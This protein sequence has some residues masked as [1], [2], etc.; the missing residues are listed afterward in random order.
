METARLMLRRQT[1]EDAGFVLAL[2]ND[3]E[4]I[5]YIGDRGVR[6]REEAQAYIQEGAVKMYDHQ[7]F[8]L[9]LV[10]SKEDR[11]PVGLC[12]LIK[13]DFLDDVDLGFALAREYRGRGYAREAAAATVAYGWE[14]VGL[15]RIVAIVSP[16]NADSLRLLEG[17][18][19]SFERV[20]DYP[21][22]DKVHLLALAM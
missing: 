19:F 8:G 15:R 17:L 5:R 10:E 3:P 11:K 7:G 4:W 6:T 18:G 20:I 14:V 16:D 22:G 13:R 12:G 9:Y 2:M 1:V 21:G